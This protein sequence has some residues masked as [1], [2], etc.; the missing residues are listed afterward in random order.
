MTNYGDRAVITLGK[1]LIDRS[2]AD[3]QAVLQLAQSWLQGGSLPYGT[4]SDPKLVASDVDDLEYQFATSEDPPR[5]LQLTLEVPVGELKAEELEEAHT[6]FW[7][8]H[9]R[10][11]NEHLNDQ[12][13]ISNW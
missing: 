1:P 9:R 5:E 12:L 3:A 2:A 8:T 13:G 4:L 7:Y 10:E 6:Y 11:L